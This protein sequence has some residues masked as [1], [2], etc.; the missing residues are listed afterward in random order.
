M[1]F[2]WGIPLFGPLIA[3]GWVA[4]MEGLVSTKVTMIQFLFNLGWSVMYTHKMYISFFL[5][6]GVTDL[7][8]L[9]S[10]LVL[11]TV[12]FMIMGYQFIGWVMK[13]AHITERI[14]QALKMSGG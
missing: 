3:L 9:L 12:I 14:H 13:K 8:L 2:L 11:S 7:G 1:I 5:S 10:R 6:M 4:I